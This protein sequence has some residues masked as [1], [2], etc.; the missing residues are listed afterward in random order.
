[1]CEIKY[2][3]NTLL[4]DVNMTTAA[5]HAF[6]RAGYETV[7]DVLDLSIEDV[8]KIRNI[9]TVIVTRLRDELEAHGINW[10]IER[11][12]Y[13]RVM[14]RKLSLESPIRDIGIDVRV[15][16]AL[17]SEGFRNVSDLLGAEYDRLI[18]I[19]GIG[20]NRLRSLKEALAKHGIYLDMDVPES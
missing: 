20:E 16:R 1:M 11:K 14:A 17:E 9:G 13:D 15:V 4:R 8:Y 6:L 18:R 7:G 5:L 3:R 19:Y 12:P 2:T 10:D